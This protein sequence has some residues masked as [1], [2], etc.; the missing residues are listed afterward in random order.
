MPLCVA[1]PIR[2]LQ[3]TM[4]SAGLIPKID[5]IGVTIQKTLESE[6][7]A[8]KPLPAGDAARTRVINGVSYVVS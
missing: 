2:L 7:L 6:G 1:T 8:V 4:E 3:Q 5:S